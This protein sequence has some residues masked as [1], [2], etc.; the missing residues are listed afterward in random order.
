[1]LTAGTR[2]DGST[3]VLSKPL[4][5]RKVV[6]INSCM[7]QGKTVVRNHNDVAVGFAF[8]VCADF[9][10]NTL[11]SIIDSLVSRFHV[12]LVALNLFLVLTPL[13]SGR[14]NQ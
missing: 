3:L 12:G 2:S 1:M 14:G 8:T 13:Y 6:D 11:N 7:E 4:S 9:I 10:N 5:C